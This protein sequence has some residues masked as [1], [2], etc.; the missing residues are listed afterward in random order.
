M[1]F[2]QPKISPF[3]IPRHSLDEGDHKGS[4][5]RSWFC[6]WLE[7][8]VIWQELLLY[9]TYSGKNQQ[10]CPPFPC[11]ARYC[12][13]VSRFRLTRGVINTIHITYCSTVYVLELR[14][15]L[16]VSNQLA[17]Q[18]QRHKCTKGPKKLALSG[19]ESLVSVVLQPSSTM[20]V[21]LAV[22]TR[23]ESLSSS[24]SR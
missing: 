9:Q 18:S 11:G 14:Y 3:R 12:I 13:K 17:N 23:I 22:K 4:L 6:A 15:H 5:T 21:S 20:L 19:Q 8:K 2:V 16:V 10:K 7:K 24:L 1:S